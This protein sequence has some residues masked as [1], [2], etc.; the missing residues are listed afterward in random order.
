M[1]PIQPNKIAIKTYPGKG[2][3]L[4]AISTIC[5]GE[6]I[7]RSPVIIFDEKQTK[8]LLNHNMDAYLWVWN[9]GDTIKKTAIS[10]GMISLCNHSS[11]PNCHIEKYYDD[12]MIDL[13]AKRHIYAGEELLLTYISTDFDD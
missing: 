10:L 9:N 6:L 13:I 1:T 2:R 8:V 4:V 5:E 12:L 11:E 7:E 3:G